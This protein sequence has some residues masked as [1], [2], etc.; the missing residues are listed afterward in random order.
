MTDQPHGL[1]RGLTNYMESGSPR[2][3]STQDGWLARGLQAVPAAG[4][5]PFRAVAMGS[6]LP[7]ALRGDVD[8]VADSCDFEPSP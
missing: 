5:S 7:R 3:K 2:V 6:Q 1:A 4:A 8:A